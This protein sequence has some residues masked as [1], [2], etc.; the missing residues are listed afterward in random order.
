MG[1]LPSSLAPF[2]KW[3]Y[4]LKPG[5]REEEGRMGIESESEVSDR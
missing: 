1:T 2:A 5:N 4:H 3:G